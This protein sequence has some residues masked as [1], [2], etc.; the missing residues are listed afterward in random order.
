MWN[1]FATKLLQMHHRTVSSTWDMFATK[2]LQMHHRTVNSKWNAFATKLQE[3]SN[4]YYITVYSTW[5]AKFNAVMNFRR[6]CRQ[7]YH[8][9]ALESFEER[10]HV[11]EIN[12]M[13]AKNSRNKTFSFLC[14]FVLFCA[15]M[16]FWYYAFKL[17]LYA[18]LHV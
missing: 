1:V 9:E 6:M 17:K 14:G 4:E 11:V 7:M 16:G 12:E 3:R 5:N 8:K 15:I 10:N 18:Q 13:T 2:L